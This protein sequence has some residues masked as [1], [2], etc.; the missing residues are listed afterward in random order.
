MPPETC[1][2]HVKLVSDISVIKND[3]GYIRDKVCKHVE[4]GEKEGGFRDRLLVIEGEVSALKKAE[5][6]R[7][8]IAGLIGGLLGK[9]TPDLFSFLVKSVFAQ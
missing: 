1:E 9:L 7:L 3:I 5:W 2:Y 8:I 6:T 4:E